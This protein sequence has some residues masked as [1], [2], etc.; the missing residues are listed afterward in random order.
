MRF[1][2]ERHTQTATGCIQTTFNFFD[3]FS[4]TNVLIS[5]PIL[6]RSQKDLSDNMYF[7]SDYKS[8]DS[9]RP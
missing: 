1:Y 5:L 7:L 4:V 2:L 3:A 8:Y 9:K 6:L